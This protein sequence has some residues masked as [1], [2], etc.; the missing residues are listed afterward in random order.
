LKIAAM[1]DRQSRDFKYGEFATIRNLIAFNWS[2]NETVTNRHGLKSTQGTGSENRQ[3]C[4]PKT[5]CHNT[6]Q[7]KERQE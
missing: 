1:G 5:Q 3:T 6:T 4:D 7:T 2:R